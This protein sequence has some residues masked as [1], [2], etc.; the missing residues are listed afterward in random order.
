MKEYSLLMALLDYLPVMLFSS[1][2]VIFIRGLYSKM[3]KGAFALFAAG[4]IDIIAAGFL[5]ATYKLLYALGIADFAVLGDIFFPL[6]SLGF[7]LAGTGIMAILLFRQTEEK[8]ERDSSIKSTMVISG[9]I[10]LAVIVL[11]IL[12]KLFIKNGKTPYFK[13]TMIFVTLMIL[14]LLMMDTGLAVM[15]SKLGKKN[16]IW[17]YAVSFISS[18][19]MGYLS[20]RNFDKA[21]MNWVAEGVNTIGQLSLLAAAVKQHNR[22]FEKLRLRGEEIL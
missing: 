13:G 15:A 4:T 7:I 18:L 17:L 16:I 12:L 2:V 1:A 11:S 8:E 22:G 14:G 20:S 3:S 9:G 5:K 19:A 6:Q 21:A 10:Y